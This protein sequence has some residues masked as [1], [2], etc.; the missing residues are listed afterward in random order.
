MNFSIPATSFVN[1]EK[2][3][4]P[5]EL[6]HMKPHQRIGWDPPDVPGEMFPEIALD[7]RGCRGCPPREAGMRPHPQPISVYCPFM[8]S[9]NYK[10]QDGHHVK[11]LPQSFI[12]MFI[13]SGR[14]WPTRRDVF[15]K[16]D[17]SMLPSH[18]CHECLLK[19]GFWIRYSSR[20]FCDDVFAFL[21]NQSCL[22]VV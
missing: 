21:L 2:I 10:S 8:G 13:F 11:Y 12:S 20:F 6:K 7:A 14:N 5:W 22:G 17:I 4:N 9:M 3:G 15:I 16:G 18:S 1:G 19:V